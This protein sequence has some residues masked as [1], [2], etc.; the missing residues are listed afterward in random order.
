MVRVS[1]LLLSL[2]LQK[3]N[4][5]VWSR[6]WPCGFSI[7]WQSANYGRQYKKPTDC[8]VVPPRNDVF[9]WEDCFPTRAGFL[10]A[11][12]IPFSRLPQCPIRADLMAFRNDAVGLF[13]CYHRNPFLSIHPYF[14]RLFEANMTKE[15]CFFNK[16]L[17]I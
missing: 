15:L 2:S 1:I 13:R 16:L 12:T 17:F 3:T 6:G 5:M 8:F 11:L 9:R 14:N 10:L 4:S 7:P